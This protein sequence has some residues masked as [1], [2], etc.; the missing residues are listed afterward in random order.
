MTNVHF[1][2]QSLAGREFCSSIDQFRGLLVSDAGLQDE[3]AS[4]EDQDDFIAT[5]SQIAAR[6]GISL[7]LAELVEAL[8]GA[9]PALAGLDAPAF[10]TD[11]WPSPQWLP[12]GLTPSEDGMAVDWTHFG[13]ARLNEPFFEDTLHHVAR[14]PLNRVLRRRTPL[15]ALAKG[16]GADG[17]RADVRAPDGL[18][19]HMSRCGSTLVSQMLAAMP[20]NIVISEAPVLDAVIQFAQ[21][22]TA[23]PEADRIAMLRAI[24]GAIGRDRHGTARRLVIKLDSWHSLALPLFRRAFPDTPWI[25]LYR[26][27][28]AVM[29][30]QARMRGL[31]TVAGA[32][33][34]LSDVA[35]E[36]PLSTEFHIARVLARIC[37]AA[38][39][40]RA[41]GGGLFVDYATLPDAV[42]KV[43]LPHFGIVPDMAENAAMLRTATRDAKTPALAFARNRDGA[44][45]ASPAIRDATEAVLAD[46]YR[47]LGA[48]GREAVA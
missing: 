46:I 44:A 8:R 43:I 2:T 4:I 16:M 20:A 38:L 36:A 22:Q 10:T 40:H 29:L 6:H 31:H 47:R 17:G 25:F 32:V 21:T 27:P 35:G 41:L 33:A 48:A 3:L 23:L 39:A 37:E 30:S 15:A 1:S 9:A 11:A 5:S 34:C 45:A 12:T 28:I 24:V 42:E 19:F 14:R 18:I 26:D 7:D 13:G